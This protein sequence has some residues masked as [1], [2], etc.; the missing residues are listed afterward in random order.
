MPNHD[1]WEKGNTWIDPCASSRLIAISIFQV[2]VQ[3][4]G[5]EVFSHITYRRTNVN[6]TTHLNLAGGPVVKNPPVNAGDMSSILGLG[7][8]HFMQAN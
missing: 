4:E 3:V 5:V 6:K 7:R 8:F 2:S 1:H